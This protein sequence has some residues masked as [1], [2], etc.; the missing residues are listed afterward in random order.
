M[1]EDPP[2][3]WE[4]LTLLKFR[5]PSKNDF[6][7]KWK[8]TPPSAS[9]FQNVFQL[10]FELIFKDKIY[11]TI[12]SVENFSENRFRFSPNVTISLLCRFC[13]IFKRCVEMPFNLILGELRS[14]E[15]M[16]VFWVI[17]L[18]DWF[19]NPCFETEM[20]LVICLFIF[21]KKRFCSDICLFEEPDPPN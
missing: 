15:I 21:C 5:Y 4:D 2:T 16:Q 19:N 11:A 7:E 1:R 18:W 20:R 8:D 13:P 17:I 14:A 3:N 12:W 6:F 10:L 9:R